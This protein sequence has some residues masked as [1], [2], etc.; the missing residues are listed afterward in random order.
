MEED[1]DGDDEMGFIIS[2]KTMCVY[3]QIRRHC[4]CFYFYLFFR[5]LECFHSLDINIHTLSFRY[6]KSHFIIIII[7][8]II[9]LHG[10][11]RLTCSG[12]D[13]LPSFPRASTISSSSRFVA[14]GVFRQSGIVHFFKSISLH[15]KQHSRHFTTCYHISTQY[16]T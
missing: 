14:E 7:T 8:T 15:N 13:A 6:T 2:K 11:S 9:F 12:I 10:L 5:F 1:D 16:T 4:F 3:N